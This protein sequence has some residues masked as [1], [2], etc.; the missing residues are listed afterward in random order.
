MTA[1]ATPEHASDHGVHADHDLA[2]P[3]VVVTVTDAGQIICTPDPVVVSS[4]NANV[5]FQLQTAG[6]VFREKDPIVV[7]QPGSTF[8]FPSKTRAGTTAVLFDRDNCTASYKYS[9]F[10]KDQATG[11]VISVDPTIRNEPA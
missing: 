11:R 8:P 9:V 2:P 4:A 6:Y 10:V 1:L 7:T 5:V 3:D